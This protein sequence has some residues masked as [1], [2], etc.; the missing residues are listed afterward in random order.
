M[1]VLHRNANIYN[2]IAEGEVANL[3]S[4][5]NSDHVM[6][7]INRNIENRFNYNP[8][9]PTPNL[10]DSFEMNF[11]DL[12]QNYPN[13]IDN[14][15]QVR[16]EVYTEIINII[17]RA[18]NL[19]ILPNNDLDA[20]IAAHNLY[21][22]FVANFN[23]NAITFFS[24]YI[25]NNRGALYDALNFSQYKKEKDS[26][27]LYFKKVYDDSEI[28]VLVS[29]IKEVTYYISGFDIDMYSYISSCGI[30]KEVCDYINS[31]VAPLSDI[32]KEQFCRTLQNPN[33]LT[34][35]RLMIQEIVDNNFITNGG[36]KPNII[37]K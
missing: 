19:Q 9:V 4:H 37:E 15:N 25:Y 10:V 14:I 13:D 5:F 22:V 21:D 12:I 34:D 8:I 1:T 33:I 35:I 23:K 3:L 6:N 16:Y 2:M 36:T 11:K 7:V 30:T 32:Y 26:S 31:I 20:Y 27:I 24:N 28:G 17:C 29:K 18:F